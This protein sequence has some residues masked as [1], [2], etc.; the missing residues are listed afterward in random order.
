[1]NPPGIADASE[2]TAEITFALAC[3]ACAASQHVASS[4]S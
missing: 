3:A 2:T 1:M 4:A